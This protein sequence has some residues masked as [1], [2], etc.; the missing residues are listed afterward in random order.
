MLFLYSLLRIFIDL[1]EDLE[2]HLIVYHPYR[3]LV[4]LTG[5]DQ[6][7]PKRKFNLLKLDDETLQNAWF[8]INDIYRSELSLLHSP[9]ILALAAIYLALGLAGPPPTQTIAPTFLAS[10]SAQPPLPSAVPPPIPSAHPSLPPRP[11]ASN[12]SLT[13]PTPSNENGTDS[14]ALKGGHTDPLTFLST[15]NVSLPLV[16]EVIQ[17]IIS[18][19]TLWASYENVPKDFLSSLSRNK[20]PILGVKNNVAPADERVL[21]ILT[22]MR[23]L[24]ER[25]LAHPDS[26]RPIAMAVAPRRSGG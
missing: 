7:D 22:K 19:Y 14:N 4:Q 1:L 20:L 18:L 21:N 2:F 3:S 6:P 11:G 12:P 24:R 16:L 13:L 9:H 15:I 5:R 8:V 23:E 17:E 26:G 10:N 25:D